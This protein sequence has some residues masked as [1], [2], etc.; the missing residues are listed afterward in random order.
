MFESLWLFHCGYVMIPRSAVLALGGTLRLERFPFMALAAKHP[1][2]GLMLV[3]APFGHDGPGNAG[4]I[5]AAML[6]RTA[7]RYEKSW[8]IIPR[9][10]ELGS[11]PSDVRHVLMTHLHF[12]HT[13]GMKELGH[14]TFHI[15]EREWS[16]AAKMGRLEALKNGFVPKDWRALRRNVSTFGSPGIFDPTR[17]GLDLFGDASVMAI[18]LPGHS[19]GMTGYR[20]AMQDGRHIFMLGDAVY[21]VA[22][23]TQRI[24]FAPPMTLFMHSL[25]QANDTLLGLQRHHQAHPDDL[26]VSSHD[27][28][29]GQLCLTGPVRL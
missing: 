4:A 3:D 27:F 25:P 17:P 29:L 24:G 11:R 1:D 9:I 26:L 20:F 7:M 19:A 6:R 8:S 22:Q 16:T 28:D 12:D 15:S 13:G 2:H 10:E 23:V 14:A 5:L 18:S 21:S